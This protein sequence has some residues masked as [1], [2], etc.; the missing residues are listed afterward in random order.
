MADLGQTGGPQ[1]TAGAFCAARVSRGHFCASGHG[2]QCL[3]WRSPSATAIARSTTMPFRFRGPGPPRNV[4]VPAA[5]VGQSHPMSWPGIERWGGTPAE[6]ARLHVVGSLEL[7]MWRSALALSHPRLQADDATL[8]RELTESREIC[9]DQMGK[10]CRTLAYPYGADDERVRAATRDAGYEAAASARLG[11]PLRF[12]WPRVGIYPLDGA[13]RFRFKVSP[14][15]AAAELHG[16]GGTLDA[17]APSCGVTRADRCRNPRRGR[18]LWSRSGS[19]TGW[20]RSRWT[21]EKLAESRATPSSPR[22]GLVAGSSTTGRDLSRSWWQSG[23]MGVASEGCAWPSHLQAAAHRNPRRCESRDRFHPFASRG[24]ARVAAAAGEALA[25]CGDPWSTVI[26]DHV[27]TGGG[28]VD[29]LERGPMFASQDWSASQ[30]ACPSSTSAIPIGRA[31]WRIEA[32]LPPAGSPVS[33]ERSPGSRAGSDE[34]SR[35]PGSTAT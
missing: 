35:A 7:T 16:V 32:Q 24:R 8:Q 14:A 34:R 2:Q 13:V 29:A 12:S 6:R 15:A 11:E 31:T 17:A 21:G 3:E 27:D 19:S 23:P 30:R 25:A 10:P 18:A 20:R 28:W 5:H 9:A 33:A 1:I 4:F 22:N 26:L